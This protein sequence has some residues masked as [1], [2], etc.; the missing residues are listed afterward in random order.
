MEETLFN[1]I[2]SIS[3]EDRFISQNKS[4]KGRTVSPEFPEIFKHI[5]F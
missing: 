1:I 5:Q 2:R 4:L 3:I